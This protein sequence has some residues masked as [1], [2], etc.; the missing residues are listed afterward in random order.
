MMTKS[1]A[2][3]FGRFN[4]PTTGH[5][6]LMDKT[7]GANRNY[8]VYASQSQD[9]KRNPLN[10]RN[11]IKY[12]KGMFPAHARKI[13]RDKMTTAL[14][15]MVQLYKEKHTDVLMIVGSD[16]VREFDSLLNK[17]NGV[18]ST[19]GRYKFKSIRVISA[20]ERDPDAE[21]VSGMSASKMRKAAQNNKYDEFKQGLPS[22]YKGGKNLFKAIQ[23]AMGVKSFREF[24]EAKKGPSETEQDRD[25]FALPDYPMQLHPDDDDGDWVIGDPTKPIEVIKPVDK[26]KTDKTN[27]AV[28]KD[29]TV[30]EK[31]PETADDWKEEVEIGEA[32]PPHLSKFFDKKGEMKP[33][34]AKRVA[35]GRKKRAAAATKAK[36]T[37][38]TPKG[39]GPNE[40]DLTHDGP[41]IAPNLH[42]KPKV[43]F[44]P[45]K[46]KKDTGPKPSD[47]MLPKDRA[48]RIE[49]FQDF[50]SNK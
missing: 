27:K 21:G 30:W 13:S 25:D 3:T 32:L 46:K 18:K 49:G 40:R 45:L 11:K 8:R 17:Y 7:R 33:D 39:Y 9:P 26:K 24:V 31:D 47:Q 35:A 22:T 50:I 48:S 20:G 44:H 1:V 29:R 19:H 28:V 36:I 5:E 16:R 14:D 42:L 12:M 38:V 4:P 37:D 43:V 10:H 41:G 34:A 15:V 2:F 6:K 23:K